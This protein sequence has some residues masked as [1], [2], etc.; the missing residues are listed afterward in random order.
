MNGGK[1]LN[2]REQELMLVH[3]LVDGEL[4]PFNA[5]AV[6][7]RIASDPTLARER[8][9]IETLHRLLREPLPRD[10][11]P[12]GLE[13]RVRKAVGLESSRSQPTWR[14]L[15][16]SVALAVVL[17]SAAT[18]FVSQPLRNADNTELVVGA[19]LRSLMLGQPTDVSSSDRHTVKPWFAG[20]IPQ[21][22]K[23]VDLQQAGFQLLGG[24]IDVAQRTGVPTL[25]YKIR[26]HVISLTAIPG[27]GGA[28]RPPTRRSVQGYNVLAWTTDDTA[29]WAVWD[30]NF[31]D[32]ENSAGLFRDAPS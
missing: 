1:N 31:G 25:V 24:R 23:V 22:P 10:I 13:E 6:E 32:L 27:N 2:A 16:A 18:W 29:Y 30:V 3:A 12:P 28:L 15:A 7:Q 26:Q 21:S 9:Q 17:S 8:A 20:R 19:H 4:D 14:A 5:K 11:P